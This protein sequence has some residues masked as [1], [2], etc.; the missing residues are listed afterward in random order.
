MMRRKSSCLIFNDCYNDKVKELKLL[1]TL[2]KPF[3]F[4]L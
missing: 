4:F 3:P 1:V 2:S